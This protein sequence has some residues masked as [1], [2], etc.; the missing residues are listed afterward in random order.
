[1]AAITL[2]VGKRRTMTLGILPAG[3]LVDGV[4]VWT[5]SPTGGVSLFPTPD[6]KSCDMLGLT[7]VAIQTITV[8]ADADLTAGVK[9]IIA[10]QDIQT[11]NPPPPPATGLGITVGAEF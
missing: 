4:P 3:A 10:T 2:T 1:M 9:P 11:Q 7:P 6:G 8:T 5:V